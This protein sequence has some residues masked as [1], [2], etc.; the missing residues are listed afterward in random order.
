MILFNARWLPQGRQ[1]PG[2]FFGT[3]C[4]GK[5]QLLDDGRMMP[6]WSM[7]SN[8]LRATSNRSDDNLRL[9]RCTGGPVVVIW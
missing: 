5:A 8:S 7:C 9:G 1:S 6:N 3:M 2:V 4:K